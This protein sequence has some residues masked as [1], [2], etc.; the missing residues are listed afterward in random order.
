MGANRGQPA[1]SCM[2]TREQTGTQLSKEAR[3][4]Q[5]N[6]SPSLSLSPSIS[7]SLS[8]LLSCPFSA[9]KDRSSAQ[10][11]YTT[12]RPEARQTEPE[13]CIYRGG[14]EEREG[15]PTAQRRWMRLNQKHTDTHMSA[16]HHWDAA[17]VRA[18]LVCKSV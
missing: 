11:S 5:N 6:S 15:R 1:Q 13:G 8:L 10:Q 7:P 14:R 3:R 18:A 16:V 17:Q 4:E 2:H 12:R 9:A